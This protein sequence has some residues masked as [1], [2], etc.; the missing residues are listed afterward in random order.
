MYAMQK[1][2]AAL[3]PV[4]LGQVPDD[5]S[6]DSLRDEIRVR[7]D[8]PWKSVLMR[9]V[10]GVF[11][12]AAL[13]ACSVRQGASGGP[14][15]E[16]HGCQISLLPTPHSVGASPPFVLSNGFDWEADIPSG[17]AEWLH[18]G[19]CAGCE[20]E[21]ASKPL[22]DNRIVLDAPARPPSV[23]CSSHKLEMYWNFGPIEEVGEPDLEILNAGDLPQISALLTG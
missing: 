6:A 21:Q 14:L 13:F 18:T 17:S 19:V 1:I 10:V 7:M 5:A 4:E 23:S 3:N 15:C 20:I 16:V 12:V 22:P 8:F 9:F 2:V 11:F